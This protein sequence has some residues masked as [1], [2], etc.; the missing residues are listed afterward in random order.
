MD[1]RSGSASACQ[2]HVVLAIDLK[3]GSSVFSASS[4]SP[5]LSR[6]AQALLSLSG[7]PVEERSWI[8]LIRLAAF[9]LILFAIARKNRA[10][11]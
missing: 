4:G 2:I 5:N 3:K 9:S 6:I 11:A 1:M 8:Y 10:R 7:I